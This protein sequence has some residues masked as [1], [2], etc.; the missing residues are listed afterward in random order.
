MKFLDLK[1]K[2]GLDR[3]SLSQKPPLRRGAVR[4]AITTLPPE[5]AT[6]MAAP[7][8]YESAFRPDLLKGQVIMVTGKIRCYY[9]LVTWVFLKSSVSPPDLVQHYKCAA[10]L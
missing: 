9:V 3:S 2:V 5:N 10:P 7:R 8:K 1:L 6:E 4:Q